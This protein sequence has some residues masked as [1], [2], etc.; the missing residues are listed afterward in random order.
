[1]TIIALLATASWGA[2][3]ICEAL[4]NS[5]II[6]R[7]KEVQKARK[8]TAQLHTEALKS[9][10]KITDLQSSGLHHPSSALMHHCNLLKPL[11]VCVCDGGVG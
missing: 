4:Q 9:K 1:M 7:E 3:D 8:Q 10:T 6:R 2:L 11:H 5:E